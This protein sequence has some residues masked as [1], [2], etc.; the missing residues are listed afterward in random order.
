[1]KDVICATMKGL[2]VATLAVT[3]SISTVRADGYEVGQ[4]GSANG[5]IFATSK[6]RL[7]LL[8]AIALITEDGIKVVCESQLKYSNEEFK[9]FKKGNQYSCEG[10]VS[11][12]EEAENF[13]VIREDSNLEAEVETNVG[14]ETEPSRS[15]PVLAH[16]SFIVFSINN[17]PSKDIDYGDLPCGIPMNQMKNNFKNEVGEIDRTFRQITNEYVREIYF[18]KNGLHKL[19]MTCYEPVFQE[20]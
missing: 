7:G 16:G 6:K 10:T 2:A 11:E 5:E 8:K 4:Q 14:D 17:G 18:S 3:L 1:M 9:A 19:S 12:Y 13:Y 15:N 20:G